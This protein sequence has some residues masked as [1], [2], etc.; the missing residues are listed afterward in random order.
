MNNATHSIPAL[1]EAWKQPCY[2]THYSFFMDYTGDVLQCPHDWGKKFIVGNMKLQDFKEIWLGRLLSTAR[3]QLA[4][5]DRNYPPCNVCD[6][7]G[8]LI[9]KKHVEAWVALERTNYFIV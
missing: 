4:Q 6:V 1:S 2:Y 5:G 7:N 3:K 9:G 8:T